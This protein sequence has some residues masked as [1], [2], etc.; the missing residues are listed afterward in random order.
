MRAAERQR[1]ARPRI[2]VTGIGSVSA[3]G[4]GD[5]AAVADALSRG[6]SAVGPIRAFP[7]DGCP[8][9]LGAE[10]GDLTAHLLDSEARRLARASQLA[11]VA[12]RLALADARL[13]PDQLSGLGLVLGS[14]W[15][16]F[17][18]PE[19]F[20]LG[21]LQRGVLGL[22]AL[23]F[24]NTVMN[25]MAA[26]VSIAVG[27][28]GPMLTLNE[29]DV[30]GD[31]AVARGAALITAGRASTV[32]AGGCD[33]ICSILFREL[34]RL[35]TMSR[36]EPGPEGCRPFDRQASGT[37]LGEGSTFV[38]LESAESA[39]A[40]SARVYGELAGAA[41]GNLPA[42]AHGFPARR[43]RDPMTV[44]RALAAAGVPSD[45]VDVAY[46]T[47]NGHPAHDACELDLVGSALG[48]HALLTAL[49]PLVGD[50]AGLGGL[51]V[52]AAALA[53]AGSPVPTLPALSEPIRPD[54]R[55]GRGPGE[56]RAG[57]ALV[58]GLARGGA[59]VALVLRAFNGRRKAAA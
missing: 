54:L 40:R 24:P 30:A 9:R 18:S 3:L 10:V 26:Q 13:Q 46:L 25:A 38:V 31:L 14:H 21:F 42:P 7:T 56:G 4:A 6:R 57:T 39:L 11:V 5:G 48:G 17:R 2:V 12:A 41:W 51:R 55:F 43:R 33:E 22:S 37:V 59:H 27:V 47:G 50:H 32:L 29:V 49:T 1:S 34:S 20:A 44:R 52:A 36:A 28:R 35:G 19:A 16:D 45:A 23:T 15:G 58:H 8:S 53:V